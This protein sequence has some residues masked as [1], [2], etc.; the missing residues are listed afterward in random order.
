MYSSITQAWYSLITTNQ[1]APTSGRLTTYLTVPQN[2]TYTI[3]Y[4]H[5]NGGRLYFSGSLATNN[6]V[7][8]I[9]EESFTVTLNTLTKYSISAEFFNSGGPAQV[10]LSWAYTGHAKQTIPSSAF[11]YKSFTGSSPLSITINPA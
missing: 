8:S 3:Y 4:F 9:S 11:S 10:L 7:D 1:L 5:D 6:F 2:D